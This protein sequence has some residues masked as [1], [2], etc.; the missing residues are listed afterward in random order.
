MLG[1]R[2]LSGSAIDGYQATWKPDSAA[3]CPLMP[4]GTPASYATRPNW[5]CEAVEPHGNVSACVDV[6]GLQLLAQAVVLGAPVTQLG[7]PL[8][9]LGVHEAAEKSFWGWLAVGGFD[10]GVD[11]RRRE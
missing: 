3:A 1:V 11:G 2:G 8:L 9:A 4:T 7:P 10:D 6:D 5:L